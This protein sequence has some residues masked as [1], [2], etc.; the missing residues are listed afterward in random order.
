MIMKILLAILMS[1]SLI[2]ILEGQIILTVDDLPEPDDVQVSARID[3]I[4]D[5]TLLPGNSGANITWD[6]SMLNYYVSNLDNSFDSTSWISNTSTPESAFF[7]LADIAQTTNCY[8]Y[9]DWVSHIISLICYYNYLI[10]NPTG[11]HLYGSTYPQSNIYQQYRNIFPLLQY[12]D[13]SISYSK[14]AIQNTIDSVFIRTVTDTSI[15]DGWGTVITPVSSYDAIRIYTSETVYD[16]LYVNGIG[17]EINRETG[18]YY[19][20]WYT[21]AM[22]FPVFQISKGILEKQ[23]DYQ[24]THFAK[25]LRKNVSV[26]ENYITSQ[27]ISVVPNPFSHDAKIIL[28]NNTSGNFSI[29]IYDLN[30]KECLRISNIHGNEYTINKGSLENGIYFFRIIEENGYVQNGKFIIN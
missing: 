15:A 8:L 23:S 30:S 4:Q 17:Q 22:G 29:I 3:S 27:N 12:G 24:V 9:H 19:Y 20:K 1:V 28:N 13:T 25:Y 26:P 2:N 7:P 10:I 5:L 11:L 18:N 6:F 21:K 16:S 14:A